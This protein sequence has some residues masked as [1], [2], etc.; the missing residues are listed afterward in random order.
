MMGHLSNMKL[1]PKYGLAAMREFL[2]SCQIDTKEMVPGGHL[3]VMDT[4][5][6]S[7]LSWQLMKHESSN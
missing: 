3:K 7:L 6:T 1:E 4:D 5:G 2:K